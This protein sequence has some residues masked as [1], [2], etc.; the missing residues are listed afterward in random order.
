MVFNR[1]KAIEQSSKD[2]II[3]EEGQ[4]ISEMWGIDANIITDE[5]I[6][7]LSAGKAL[8][9]DDGEYAHVL[10]KSEEKEQP[11]IETRVGDTLIL[12]NEC[13]LTTED[14]PIGDFILRAGEN[15]WK[16][17]TKATI[18]IGDGAKLVYLDFLYFSDDGETWTTVYKNE[19]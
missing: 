16:C 10:V 3:I 5:H 4:E 12:S 19:M 18:P 8:Y 2:V 13:M 15:H 11:V 14:I 7:A 17:H 6:K 9:F 1:E